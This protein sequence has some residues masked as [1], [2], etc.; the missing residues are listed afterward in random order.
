MSPFKF[1]QKVNLLGDIKIPLQAKVDAHVSQR[2]SSKFLPCCSLFIG[3]V[4][5]DG[6]LAHLIVLDNLHRPQ[7]LVS[8]AVPSEDDGVA[9]A[10]ALHNE[11]CG[12]RH[13]AEQ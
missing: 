11:R 2:P 9:G 8:G 3:K 6:I 1:F 12:V 7:L 10:Q 5:P 13:P 4:S